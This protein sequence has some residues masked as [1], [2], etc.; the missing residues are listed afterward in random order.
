LSHSTQPNGPH[1]K[2]LMASS[3]DHTMT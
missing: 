3:S 2:W 1:A